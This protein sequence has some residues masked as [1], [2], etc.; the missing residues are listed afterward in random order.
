MFR[1]LW[2]GSWTEADQ[3]QLLKA[4]TRTD[5]ELFA[6]TFFGDVIE[7]AWSKLHRTLMDRPKA[8]WRTRRDRIKRAVA[9]PRGGAKST[10][11]TYFDLLH[12][13]V[14]A[15]EKFIVVVSTDYKLSKDLVGDLLNALKDPDAAPELHRVFGPIRVKGGIEGFVVW[16]P[17]GDA[18]GIRVMP[19]SLNGTVRGLKHALI[20]PTRYVLDDLEHPKHV[21][22]AIQRDYVETWVNGDV[23][24]GGR[25]GTITDWIGTIL[26]SDAALARAMAGSGWDCEFFKSVIS[27]PKARKTLWEDCRRVWANLND[28]RR[29]DSART[30]YLERK[31]AM[32]EGAEVLWPEKEPLF[33]LMVMVWS[34]GIGAFERDM[35]NNP[36]DPDRSFFMPD[37]FAKC[38]LDDVKKPRFLTVTSHPDHKQKGR[39]VAIS[40]LTVAIWH[41][42]SKGGKKNDYPAT[43]VVG[44]CAKDWRY[45]LECDLTREKTSLQQE[46]IWAC[47]DRYN[48]IAR[49]VLVGCDDTA[50]TETFADAFDR[51][52][53]KRKTMGQAWNLNVQSFTLD[54]DKNAR[55]GRHE[56]LTLHGHVMFAD[57]L[58]PILWE[59][60]RDHPTA[61][62]D[63]GPD[64][65]ERADWLL[66]AGEMPAPTFSTGFGG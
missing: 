57:H 36:R 62:H 41:D 66:T 28:K 48:G 50:Q 53:A 47:W 54:E 32:D 20:R 46:R 33:D 27:W 44:K 2:E 40:D 35:Q 19:G 12:D 52:R 7:C 16:T 10:V 30:F 63:D 29:L 59:M 58:P 22:E 5:N 11:L 39:R 24:K 49:K 42:R 34:D 17:Q 26:H 21:L 25:R 3:I 31:A 64:A 4:R 55:I 14:H 18:T 6:L 61:A 60:Y 23:L 51:M 65:I 45:V 1:A 43:A 38:A 9:A 56:P 8:H 15:L 13:I 37:D